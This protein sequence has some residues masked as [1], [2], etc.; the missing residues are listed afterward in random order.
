MF[1]FVS[2]FF[3]YKIREQEG[4]TGPAGG[5]GGVW[6]WG[7]AG[8]VPVGGGRWWGKRVR[9]VNR[10]QKMYAQVCKWKND[11]N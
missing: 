9:R 11:T 4:R 5:R 3:F 10:V 6:G 7:H 2:S 8:V 1:F